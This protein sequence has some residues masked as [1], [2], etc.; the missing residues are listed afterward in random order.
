MSGRCRCDQ[1]LHHSPIETDLG[2]KLNKWISLGRG[3]MGKCYVQDEGV[4]KRI[5]EGSV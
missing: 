3:L 1:V 4:Y 5:E 2:L